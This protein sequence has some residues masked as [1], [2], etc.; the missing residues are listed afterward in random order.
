MQMWFLLQSE[1]E[2]ASVSSA[3]T[4]IGNEWKQSKASSSDL[5][6]WFKQLK[7]E[8]ITSPVA[9]VWMGTDIVKLQIGALFTC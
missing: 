7:I 8:K 1:K 4:L 9:G 6:T 3:A 5:S 2:F